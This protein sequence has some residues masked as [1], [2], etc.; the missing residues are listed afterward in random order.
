MTMEIEELI[1]S[2]HRA[3]GAGGVGQDAAAHWRDLTDMGWFMMTVPEEDG[4]LGL[5]WDAVV[6]IQ[7][8]LGRVLASGAAMAQMLVVEALSRAQPSAGRDD[9]LAQAM[10]G[11]RFTASLQLSDA[12]EGLSAYPDADLAGHMLLGSRE[13]ISI[14][15]IASAQH[16]QTWDATRRLFDVTAGDEIL[17]LATGNEAAALADHLAAFLGTSLAADALGGVQAVLDMTVEYVQTRRQFDR[18][19]AAFQALK[20]RLSDMKTA[21]VGAEALMWAQARAAQAGD[22]DVLAFG[23]MKSCAC[24]AYQ[25]IAEQAIQLHGGIGLT[26][27]HPAHLYFKRAFLNEVLGG[28]T[29]HWTKAIGAAALAQAA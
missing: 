25:Q 26:E 22:A 19:L 18:P 24:Q 5:G 20:H 16:R 7:R 12:G 27:E 15:T 2:A 29:D 3:F 8:E 10:G 23:G 17:V 28:S 13:K 9:L 4:G 1:E 14:N 11:E 6:V 21:L